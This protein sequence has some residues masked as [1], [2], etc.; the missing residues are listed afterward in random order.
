MRPEKRAGAEHKGLRELSG[1]VLTQVKVLT[2]G[3]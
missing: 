3:V 2:H 1:G